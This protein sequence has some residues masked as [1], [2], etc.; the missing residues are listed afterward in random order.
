MVAQL[1][2]LDDRPEDRAHI[3][4]ALARAH[5]DLD[6]PG[7]AFRHYSS[8]N[9]IRYEAVNYRPEV[10]TELVDRSIELFTPAFFAARSRG[11]ANERGPIFVIGMPRAG[12]TLVEQILAS[13]PVIE[14]TAELANMRTIADE[15]R[16]KPGGY[17]ISLADLDVAER[18]ALGARYLKGTRKVRRTSRPLFVD[19]NPNN[20]MH[21]GLIQLILPAAKIIDV[22][23]HPL[24][25]CVANFRQ[26][27][28]RGQGFSYSLE[29]MGRY[30]ADY[31]R[32]MRH[33]DEVMPGR[34]HRLIYEDLVE[35]PEPQVE[36][37]LQ[38]I[39]VDFDPACLRFYETDRAVRTPS[40]LQV[41]QPLSRKGIGSWRRFE[42]WLA[43]LKET[44]GTSVTDYRR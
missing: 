17:P 32:L 12:S 5:E 40:S 29:H 2:G 11:G 39:G 9:R 42:P 4:F 27:F 35:D 21:V 18:A 44:L 38:H 10:I 24:D 22:R 16:E 43:P 30:Y 31:V 36:A 3:Y 13:H 26:L 28:A 41:R 15:L 14:G 7:E 19:K 37:L 25:C 23:R 20:W 1:A 6:E 34:V 33:F 8:G